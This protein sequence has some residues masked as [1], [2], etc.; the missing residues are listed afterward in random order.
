MEFKNMT[1]RLLKKANLV[2]ELPDEEPNDKE[3]DAKTTRKEGVK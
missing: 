2:S 1:T 3:L